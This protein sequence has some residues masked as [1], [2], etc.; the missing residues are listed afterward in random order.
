MW[1]DAAY[2]AS[3]PREAAYDLVKSAQTERVMKAEVLAIARNGPCVYVGSASPSSR[4]ASA[5][6]L[7]LYV[8]AMLYQVVDA[9]SCK[10]LCIDGIRQ[11]QPVIDVAKTFVP[12]IYGALRELNKFSRLSERM[13]I[14]TA[15]DV[16]PGMHKGI[17]S[18]HR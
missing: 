6:F 5:V 13:E 11:S 2:G 3:M 18:R 4:S 15:A 9:S 8:I 1:C 17:V 10:F 14:L 16:D 7:L 12:E